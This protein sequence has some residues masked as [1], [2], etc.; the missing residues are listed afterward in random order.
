MAASALS[1]LS[2]V[3]RRK[4]EPVARKVCVEHLIVLLD[5][6]IAFGYGLVAFT[7]E[8]AGKTDNSA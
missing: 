3:P 7:L 8:V 6:P 4:R 5:R 1:A 2:S